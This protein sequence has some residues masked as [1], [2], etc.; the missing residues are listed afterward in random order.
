MIGILIEKMLLRH[1]ITHD[2]YPE[3]EARY[4][5]IREFEEDT[6]RKWMGDIIT[7]YCDNCGYCNGPCPSCVER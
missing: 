5:S 2:G 4:L 7:Q 3:S 6:G 1:R